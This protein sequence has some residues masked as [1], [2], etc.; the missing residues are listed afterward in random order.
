M[1]ICTGILITDIFRP[2]C[3]NY[4]EV[5]IS[6][7]DPNYILTSQTDDLFAKTVR[8]YSLPS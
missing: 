4:L 1:G 5:V 3:Y 8:Y 2:S 7:Y 6:Y